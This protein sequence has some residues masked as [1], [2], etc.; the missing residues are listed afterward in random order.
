MSNKRSSSHDGSHA[1]ARHGLKPRPPRTASGTATL[2]AAARRRLRYRR[3]RNVLV[4]APQNVFVKV[5]LRAPVGTHNRP[6]GQAVPDA[7]TPRST[8]G[9]HATLAPELA[10][11]RHVPSA[12]RARKPRMCGTCRVAPAARRWGLCCRA[13]AWRC[14]GLALPC[15]ALHCAPAATRRA[16]AAWS[17]RRGGSSV[18]QR[19]AR[20]RRARRV[21]RAAA[22]ARVSWVRLRARAARACAPCAG[23]ITLARTARR[24]V[25]RS[26]AAFLSLALLSRPYACACAPLALQQ[27]IRSAAVRLARHSARPSPL[28]PL[29]RPKWSWPS[30]A[31]RAPSAA[32]WCWA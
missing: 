20:R 16:L 27:R 8:G 11:R 25:V 23:V 24:A 31:R 12:A 5:P 30:P 4:H 7:H 1:P 9:T 22:A 29:P 17:F 26:C 28:L 18:S 3:A 10:W 19:C 21:L 15:C 6:R 14:A 32:R 13:A 2:R